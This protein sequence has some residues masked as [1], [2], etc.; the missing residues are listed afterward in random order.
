MTSL[1]ALVALALCS[2]IVSVATAATNR[3]VV[4][5]APASTLLERWMTAERH[6]S[7]ADLERYVGP[8]D[9]EPFVTDATLRT[10]ERAHERRS[11]AR[12]A[13]GIA[14]LA[15]TAVLVLPDGRSAAVVAEKLRSVPGIERA[16][17]Q[18]E[19]T[20]IGLPNDP[21]ATDQYYLSLIRATDAWEAI[22]ADATAVV[23]IVDTGIDTSHPDLAD[24]IWTNP[25]ET[26][27][28]GLN[29]DRR[30]NG[31]D[32]DG[33]GF[34]DDW[35]GWDF[36][37]TGN[38]QGDNS[39]LPG[40]THGT[41]V[42]GIVGAS[43]NN[44]IGI[45]GTAPR[46][47]LMAVKVGEDSENSRSVSRTAD[48]ILYAAANGASIINCSFGSGAA[49]FADEDV[50]NQATALGALIVAA[51]G[52]DNTNQAFYPAAF[53][54]CVSVAATTVED[55]KAG[56]SNYHRTVDIAAP[57]AVIWST[58]LRGSYAAFDGTSMA[59]PVVAAVAA[60][61]R[62]KNPS[63]SPA[64][65]AATLKA[66]AR[67]IDAA[68]PS[69]IGRI[70][71][72]RVDAFAAVSQGSNAWS[73]VTSAT[74]RDDDGDGMLMPGDDVRVT[75]TVRNDLGPLQNARIVVSALPNSIAPVLVGSTAVL[76]PMA[77]GATATSSDD[78]ALRLPDSTPLN[79]MLELL[80]TIMDGDR[81]VG[82]DLV[83]TNVNTTYRTISEN[84]IT[85]TVTSIGALG[86]ND[87]PTNG[88]GVGFS[89]RS[90]RDLL[91]EAGLLVGTA[92]NAL[93]NI[94]RTGNAD[95]RDT[96]FSIV[97][98][99]ALR[100]DSVVEGLRAV[101]RYDDRYERYGPGVS[102]HQHTYQSAADSVRNTILLRYDVTNT[103]DTVQP[104]LHVAMF[105]DWDLGPGGQ[106]NG[107]GWVNADGIGV[108]ENVGRTDLPIVGVSMLSG[109]ATNFYAVDNDATGIEL[110][111]YDGFYRG[112]KWQMMTSGVART[113]SRIGDVSMMIGGGPIYLEPGQTRQIL[114]AIGAGSDYGTLRSGM[115]A[116]RSMAMGLGLNAVPYTA[117]PPSDGI[118]SVTSMPL[119]PGTTATISYL[120][121]APSG[122]IFDLVDL[123]GRIVAPLGMVPYLP[124]GTHTIGVSIPA[125][126][127]GAYFVRMES[128]RTTTVMPALVLR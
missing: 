71:T 126:T 33:N 85:T 54:R 64:E 98:I 47:R 22:P 100:T 97:D 87:Y 72:G 28:D 76:G 3:V 74:F 45:A 86:Y 41:H 103:T 29:R 39:P 17:V 61:V 91:F 53:E 27:M 9:T 128:G 105:M 52:N 21:L 30:T 11:L 37:G 79:A 80:V 127:P 19:Q 93:S 12:T 16:D 81:L 26:G 94:V 111:I 7:I 106:D 24:N 38:G 112:E 44:G 88:Q 68:N 10:V 99:V 101:T 13:P 51:A 1:R 4:R 2:Q 113:T 63:F 35:M 15:R 67:D 65:V 96:S 95:R 123:M 78:I 57:G 115:A 55:R 89:Y 75:I 109:Y 116:T 118:L 82:R 107:C 60:M 70:G 83:A 34:V 69:F 125:L 114:F 73:T 124:A 20:I 31:V 102:I 5:F 84:D 43:I 58:V 25:G 92:P 50:I 48:A 36:V 18:P 46:I 119:V 42:A 23:A 32:D 8:H 56:F 120:L 104:N 66:T 90:S 121:A 40:H 14:P 108:V 77:S 110:G 59:S 117:I 49:T 6:G 122:A 62:M